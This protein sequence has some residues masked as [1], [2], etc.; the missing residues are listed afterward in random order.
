MSGTPLPHPLLTRIYRLESAP[1]L[2]GGIFTGRTLNGRLLPGA[3]AE[4]DTPMPDGSTLCDLRYTLQT[5]EGDLLH[6]RSRGVNAGDDTFRTATDIQTDA[7]NLGWLNTG[8]FV[9]VAVWH[10]DGMIHETYLVD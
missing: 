3:T 4:R 10:D 5:R 7:P 6:V 8:V 9:G 2:A 1:D